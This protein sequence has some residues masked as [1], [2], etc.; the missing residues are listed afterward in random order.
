MEGQYCIGAPIF[1]AKNYPAASIWITAPATRLP[2][3]QLDDVGRLIRT[4]ADIISTRLG[5]IQPPP[6]A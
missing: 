2:D 4:H 5:C 3:S 1:D 6:T